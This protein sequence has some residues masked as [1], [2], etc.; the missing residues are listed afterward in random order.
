MWI[1]ID[2][3]TDVILDIQEKPFG[4]AEGWIWVE[5]KSIKDRSLVGKATYNR[6]EKEAVL[7]PAE[8]LPPRPISNN[9]IAQKLVELD[10]KIESTKGEKEPVLGVGAV[11]EASFNPLYLLLIPVVVG[12][13]LLGKKL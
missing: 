3:Q 13:Y 2:E 4:V 6:Q 12:A 10:A 8:P 11:S 5:D 1:L 9:E 7:L